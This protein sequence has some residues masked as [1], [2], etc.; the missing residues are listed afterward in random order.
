VAGWPRKKREIEWWAAVHLHD[1]ND[2]CQPVDS[3]IT[4]VH[5]IMLLPPAQNMNTLMGERSRPSPAHAGVG[6]IRAREVDLVGEIWAREV[7]LVAEI[8][9]REVDLVGKIWVK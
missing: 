3:I 2:E 8:W 6:E 9:A 1:G 7:D 4:C 5:P